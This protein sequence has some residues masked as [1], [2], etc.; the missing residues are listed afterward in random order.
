M[1]GGSDISEK[2]LLTSNLIS[3]LSKAGSDTHVSNYGC[4]SLLNPRSTERNMF[5]FLYGTSLLS[6]RGFFITMAK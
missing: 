6:S 1:Q 5:V 3:D 4:K 2:Y